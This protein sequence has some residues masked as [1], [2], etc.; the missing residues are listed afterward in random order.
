MPARPNAPDSQALVKEAARLIRSARYLT[1][2]TGAGISVESGIPPSRGEGGLWNT[3]DERMFELLARRRIF[4]RSAVWGGVFSP[5]SCD[6][7]SCLM[8]RCLTHSV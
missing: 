8:A 5:V 7:V 2:F 3:Y 1:A 4:R 6:P